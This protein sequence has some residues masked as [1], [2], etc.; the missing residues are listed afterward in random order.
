MP[1]EAGQKQ[2]GG[3]RCRLIKLAASLRGLIMS[4][5][6]EGGRTMLRAEKRAPWHDGW[7]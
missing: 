2:A 4:H 1:E 3:E 6:E 7:G 5:R